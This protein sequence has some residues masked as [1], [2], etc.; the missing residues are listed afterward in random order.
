MNSAKEWDLFISYASE[1]KVEFVT[2]LVQELERLGIRVWFDAHT[3]RLG[4]KLAE[5]IDRGLAH[6]RFGVVVLSHAFF[7]K[8][9]PKR[10]LAGLVQ[11]EVAAKSVIL[12]I[13]HGVTYEDVLEFSSTLANTIAENSEHGISPVARA[14]A[15]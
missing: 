4:S 2:P 6:S 8:R 3:L 12:P 15:K 7:K 11:R 5:E 14:I 13:W 10:E 9:W 1:D